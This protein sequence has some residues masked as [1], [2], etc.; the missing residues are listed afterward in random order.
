MIQEVVGHPLF[1]PEQIVQVKAIVRAR[2]GFPNNLVRDSEPEKTT[3]GRSFLFFALAALVVV[4][5]T[6][7]EACQGWGA[8]LF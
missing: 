4:P 1:P 7:C 5:V 2:V 3:R 8:G 6:S